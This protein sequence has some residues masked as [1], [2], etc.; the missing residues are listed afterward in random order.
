MSTVYFVAV[1]Y[2][3]I[4]MYTKLSTDEIVIHRKDSY[5]Q[6]RKLF[7]DEV[8][9]VSILCPVQTMHRDTMTHG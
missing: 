7:T 4:V 2:S 8:V 1:L 6:I 5:S 3:V 9:T